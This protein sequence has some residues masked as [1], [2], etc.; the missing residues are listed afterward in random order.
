MHK[1]TNCT[2]QA[3]LLNEEGGLREGPYHPSRP[4]PSRNVGG[5]LSFFGWTPRPP[6]VVST[7]ALPLNPTFPVLVLPASHLNVTIALLVNPLQAVFLPHSRVA[8]PTDLCLVRGGCS[9]V[10]VGLA[11]LV[12]SGPGAR[13]RLWVALQALHVGL[14]PASVALTSGT[15]PHHRSSG[16]SRFCSVLLV[17]GVHLCR[18]LSL[19]WG[20]PAPLSIWQ[21]DCC[22]PSGPSACPPHS[23]S[24]H[25]RICAPLVFYH[26]SHSC[27]V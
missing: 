14:S 17:S 21:T 18:W 16:T 1:V 7:S 23:G 6:S 19:G 22:S 26:L 24:S 2:R 8:M 5:I 9:L 4:S 13:P 11:S 27:A 10:L 25:L 20:H 3:S 15:Y 12:P